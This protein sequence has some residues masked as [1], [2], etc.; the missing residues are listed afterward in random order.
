MSTY[1]A[2][3]DD[4][5]VIRRFERLGARVALM[6]QDRIASLEEDLAKEDELGR[7]EK[8]NCGTFRCETRT[9]R[10]EIMLEI[11]EKLTEYRT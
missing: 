2:S 7:E 4:L 11:K 5:F 10:A 9:R 6:M 1:V 3:D 8:S